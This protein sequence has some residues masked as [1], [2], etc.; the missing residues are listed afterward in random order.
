M[1][2]RTIDTIV[3]IVAKYS[4]LDGAHC[5]LEKQTYIGDEKKARKLTE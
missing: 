3:I 2:T 1:I 5:E 4:Y